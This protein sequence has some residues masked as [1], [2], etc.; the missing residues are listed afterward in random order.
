M[1]GKQTGTIVKFGLIESGTSK[2][3]KEYRK[4]DVV[5]EWGNKF[6]E[7]MCATAFNDKVDQLQKLNIGDVVTLEYSA[8]SRAWNDKFF[9]N[10]NMISIDLCVDNGNESF[11]PQAGDMNLPEDDDSSLPF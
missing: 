7:Y 2:A 4:Q 8:T 1:S 6:K 11:K 10:I 3:G 9:H 5:I